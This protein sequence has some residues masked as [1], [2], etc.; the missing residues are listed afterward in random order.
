M[1]GQLAQQTRVFAGHPKTLA[2]DE[3]VLR[4]IEHAGLAAQGH[5][6][7]W[8]PSDGRLG[9]EPDVGLGF[10][11][12]LAQQHGQHQWVVLSALQGFAGKVVQLR[13]NGGR[14]RHRRLLRVA[15]HRITHQRG[16]LVGLTGGGVEEGGGIAA[17][18][19]YDSSIFGATSPLIGRR[20]RF[21]YSQMAG[22]LTYGGVISGSLLL[23]TIFA[24]L[25]VRTFPTRADL[26]GM[27]WWA[28]IGGFFG[29]H[30]TAWLTPSLGAVVAA[31]M[32][33]SGGGSVYP[34]LSAGLAVRF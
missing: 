28:W 7:P 27:P 2:I 26:A 19:V 12:V 20:Y 5:A 22:T 10:R 29:G 11:Q 25:T 32:R 14:L 33:V 13:R 1:V 4:V 9:I 30:G 17:A 15:V 3:D 16:G 6:L 31:K 34:S 21:E 18:L 23:L 8:R 24:L